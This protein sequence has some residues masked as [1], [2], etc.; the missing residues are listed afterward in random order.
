MRKY[1]LATIMS[2]CRKL[3]ARV[4][5]APLL[6]CAHYLSHLKFQTIERTDTDP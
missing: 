6:H 1:L 5:I 3:E 2:V 4:N